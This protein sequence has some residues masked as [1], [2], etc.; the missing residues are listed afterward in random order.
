MLAALVSST[1]VLWAL[2]TV[3]H[4]AGGRRA[5]HQVVRTGA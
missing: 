1:V 5:H 3:R 2:S 4:A